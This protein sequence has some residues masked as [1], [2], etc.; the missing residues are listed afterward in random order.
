MNDTFGGLYTNC[1]LCKQPV[2]PTPE[3]PPQRAEA[4]FFCFV[5]NSQLQS[6]VFVKPD[7]IVGIEEI[8]PGSST[9]VLKNGCKYFLK[10]YGPYL[11]LQM[12][13]PEYYGKVGEQS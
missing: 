10:G 13:H 8:E 11:V 4:P 1:P 5:I 6:Y 7:E 3:A 9:L 2:Q 12:L